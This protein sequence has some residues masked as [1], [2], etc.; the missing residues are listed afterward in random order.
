[1]LGLF[2]ASVG[3]AWARG[4]RIDCG[5]FGGGGTSAAVTWPSYAIEIGRDVGFALLALWLG[6]HPTS[7]LALTKE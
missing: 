6:V 5:C 7:R 4:L 1:L 3:S 2:A